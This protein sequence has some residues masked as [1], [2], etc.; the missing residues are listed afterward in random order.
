MAVST[1][2]IID[3]GA[4]NLR[5]V[6]KALA[7]VGHRSL[8]ASQ[9]DEILAAGAVILPGVGAFAACMDGLERTG[10]VPVVS[11][12]IHSGKPFLGICLGLQLL[13]TESEEGAQPERRGKEEQG[14]GRGFPC[15][16]DILPG[17]VVRFPAGRKIPQIGWN[18]VRLQR[19]DPLFEGIPDQSFFYF[20]HSYYAVPED[21]GIIAGAST[22]GVEFAAAIHK[23]NLFAVQFHPEKSGR[24]GLR[25]LQNFA[26]LAEAG[27]ARRGEPG[28]ARLAEA[29]GR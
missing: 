29:G 4:G 3:Y 28:R 18:Q 14:P 23:D 6:E 1:V 10:L 22:Y 13:F 15:G 26:R 5:S 2:A 11:Q 25:L 12:A 21:P 8:I 24:P 7:R 9:P 16:L 20:V 27:S 17:R 19:P